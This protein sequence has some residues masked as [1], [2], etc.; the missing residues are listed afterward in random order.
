VRGS[1]QRPVTTKSGNKVLRL[2]LCT[3]SQRNV[4]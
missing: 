3:K 2:M 1:G 4:A